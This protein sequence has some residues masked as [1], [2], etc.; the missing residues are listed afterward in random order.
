MMKPALRKAL[1][2]LATQIA[3]DE[4]LLE[5]KRLALRTMR[6]LYG[7]SAEAAAVERPKRT[8]AT[9]R[10]TGRATV[11]RQKAKAA[12]ALRTS[13]GRRRE[14]APGSLPARILDALNE[15]AAPMKKA[16]LIE[17]VKAPASAV[18]AELKRLRADGQV[19]TVGVTSSLRYATQ[20]YAHVIVAED[21]E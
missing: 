13:T 6:E 15:N 4:A 12:R 19:V 14:L 21:G 11:R 17:A 5:R 18:L 10:R 7:E 20:K 1:E 8:K 9:A 16:P 2:H 3:L